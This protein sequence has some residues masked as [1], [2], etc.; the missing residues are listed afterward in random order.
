[1]LRSISHDEIKTFQEDGV[2]CVRGV[3]DGEWIARLREAVEEVPGGYADRIFMWTFNDTFKELA[4]DSPLGE[5]AAIC[6]SSGSCGLL[7]DVVFVKQPQSTDVTPWHHDVPYYQVQG[8]DLCG[9]W[10]GLDAT[11]LD[12][13]GIRWIKGSHKWGRIFEPE[14]FDDRANTFINPGREPLPDIDNNPSDYD[15]THFETEPGDCIISHSLVL[16]SGGPNKTDLRRRAIAFHCYGDNTRFKS[17]PPSRG[18]EDARDLGL[19]DGDPS[20]PRAGA[21]GVAKTSTLRMA[22]STGVEKPS[23]CGSSLQR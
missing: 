15:L 1:M 9:I 5:L 19:E 13:G 11:N 23:R 22:V 6:M 3:V 8:T 10:L 4:F 18:F 14:L 2:V 21:T 12:N 7:A 16:H 17:I 20:R